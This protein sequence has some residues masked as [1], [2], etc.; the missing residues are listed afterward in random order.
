VS[1]QDRPVLKRLGEV[2][3]S[4]G[5][6]LLLQLRS[7][8]AEETVERLRVLPLGDAAVR[9]APRRGLWASV[10]AFGTAIAL[11]SLNVLPVEV[12]FTA[13]AVLFVLVRLVP[14]ERVYGEINWPIIFLL[15]ALIPVGEALEATGGTAL[16]VGAML[17]VAGGM[18]APVTLGLLLLLAMLLTN[19][20]NNAAAAVLLAPLAI[21]FAR[22]L[23]ASPDA[24]LMAV[25]VGAGSAFLTP[26]G[27]Q[28]ATLV[29]EPGGYRFGDYA[30]LGVPLTLMVLLLG[31]PLLLLVWGG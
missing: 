26:I 8:D 31:V 6:V 30:R 10:A 23:E 29:L 27:H 2:R 9:F 19:V 22:G 11:T 21:E 20:V 4:V 17:H 7:E 1:R 25:A 15:A 28:S 12:A 16:I 24:Y 13:V 18:P 14:L 5:D 3:F